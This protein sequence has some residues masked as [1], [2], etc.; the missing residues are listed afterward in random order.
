MKAIRTIQKILTSELFW[1]LLIS[2]VVAVV[3]S[4]HFV[5]N[6]LHLMNF[7]APSRLNISRKIIDNLTPGL[8]QFGNVWPPLPHILMLP[9]V[10]IDPLWHSG[11]AGSIVSGVSFIGS[12][13][14]LY[15]IL[16][17]LMPR[18]RIARWIG[19]VLFL[20]N[21]NLLLLQSMAMSEP[22]F[23]FLT[24]GTMWGLLHWKHEPQKRLLYL[25]FAGVCSAASCLVRY[26]GFAFAG[27]SVLAVAYTVYLHR[28]NY[29]YIEGMTIL[30]GTLAFL[31]I[32][33]WSIYLWAIFGDPLYWA[34]IYSH[35]R[36]IISTDVM[37][38]ITV[39]D[40]TAAKTGRSTI[41]KAAD[42]TLSIAYMSGI[43]LF[44][45]GVLSMGIFLFRSHIF[46]DSKA[47]IVLLPISICAFT[48]F[49]LAR[50]SIPVV[51]PWLT[52][53]TLTNFQTTYEFEYNVRY[54]IL[55]FP[56]LV[57]LISWFIGQSR[58]LI[59]AGVAIVVLHIVTPLYR[60]AFLMYQ[61]PLKWET[62]SATANAE[63][64][65]T[66]WFKDNYD[67]GKILISAL[68]H[69]PTMFH[70]GIPYKTFI[71]EGT[72]EYWLTSRA[73][74][75]VYADWIYMADISNIRGGLGAEQ[76]SV[77]KYLQNIPTLTV[78]FEQRYNDGVIA[79]YK[80]R[81]SKS[82]NK[83]AH[84]PWKVRSV[85]TMKVSRDVAKDWQRYGTPNEAEIRK[86]LEQIVSWNANYVAIDTPY[87]Q[88]FYPFLKLWVNLAREY[89]LS[90][91]FRGNWSSWEGWFGY[92]K[93]LTPEEHIR[94]TY[95]FI[96][97]HPDLFE[98]G[99]S[100]TACPECENGGPGD[101]RLTGKKEE[102]RKLLVDLHSVSQQAFREIGKEVSTSWLSVNGDIAKEVLDK[103]TIQ[104]LD[105]I[106]T[107]DHY[108][109]PEEMEK[110]ISFLINEY[111]A[112]ILI[113]EYGVGGSGG[114]DSEL[115]Q[116]QN[117]EEML[118]ILSGYGDRIMGLNY[119]VNVGGVTGLLDENTKNALAAADTLS[120]YFKTPVFSGTIIDSQNNPISNVLI[121][122]GNNST[123]TNSNGE[124][125]LEIIPGKYTIEI[126]KEGY[127]KTTM[128]FD[129]S[130]SISTGHKI[131]MELFNDF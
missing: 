9:F 56:L 18:K 131:S 12:A 122:S 107:I 16:K 120:Q 79:I 97:Q 67:G 125:S 121:D 87:D 119:W 51:V 29:F 65:A 44:L 54:G 110:D 36:S 92:P 116:Q 108:V 55:L 39:L 90:V 109:S 6:G 41:L 59:I 48:I 128:N 70:L 111:N 82:E 3:A 57:I 98:N 81:T 17:E 13:I 127:Q 62:G 84:V 118:E 33:L 68:K 43:P 58:L 25:F 115:I 123:L 124:F 77:S 1:V 30:Y 23:I 24:L 71:H 93:N 40:Q 106:L 104:K 5:S 7:D 31:G 100:F 74:P 14:F 94:K 130:K 26:E 28:K 88:E 21:I 89:G 46:K 126:S 4:V 73:R 35:Q 99:D 45:V 95:E 60:N 83:L 72:G 103:E 34:K 91:W 129:F 47:V 80:K 86:Y 117:L 53:D 38:K 37:E 49:T 114:D 20:T 64:Q 61:L 96:K 66:K 63:F 15:L 32:A 2:S 112:K 22:L 101:P 76:D 27:A 42:Y 19:I 102:F 50:G 11:I 85:D 10:M 52:I 8:G 69:D 75:E 113:G 78:N 105:G